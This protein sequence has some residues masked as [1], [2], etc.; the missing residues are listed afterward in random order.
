MRDRETVWEQLAQLGC[1]PLAAGTAATKGSGPPHPARPCR[2]QARA[3]KESP[4]WRE[5]LVWPRF[6]SPRTATAASLSGNPQRWPPVKGLPPNRAMHYDVI[7][8]FPYTVAY[9]L[10][11]GDVA[12]IVAVAHQKRYTEYWNPPAPRRD[13][14]LLRGPTDSTPSIHFASILTNQNTPS[15]LDT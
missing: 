4:G 10:G 5:A 2:S 11:A 14:R 13:R 1:Q 12:E 9:Q 7:S 15:M 6:E 3:A 8:G